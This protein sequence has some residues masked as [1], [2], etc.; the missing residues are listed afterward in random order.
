MYPFVQ[1][2][3]LFTAFVEKFSTFSVNVVQ[4]L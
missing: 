4:K 2:T 1:K 3:K